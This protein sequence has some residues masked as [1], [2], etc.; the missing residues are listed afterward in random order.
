[1][2]MPGAEVSRRATSSGAATATS[3]GQCDRILA[4]TDKPRRGAQPGNRLA[5]RHGRRSADAVLR[6]KA[7]AASRKAA[8]A[9]LVQLGQLGQYRCRPRPIRVDQLQHLDPVGLELLRRLG[10]GGTT[11]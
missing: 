7:G 8:A 10:V 9:I 11:P 4:Q 1:M 3:P 5:W 2:P 6:R